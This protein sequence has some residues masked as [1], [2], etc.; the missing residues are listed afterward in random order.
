[1]PE[2]A[3]WLSSELGE[4][5]GAL[6]ALLTRV[7]SHPTSRDGLFDPDRHRRELVSG[8]SGDR[9]PLPASAVLDPV[10]RHFNLRLADLVGSGRSPRVTRPRQVAMYLCHRFTPA[11]TKEIGA[12]FA[13]GHSAVRNAIRVVERTI[14][15]RAT[16]RYQVEALIERLDP[17]RRSHF[18]P[19]DPG[20]DSR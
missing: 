8:P 12:I 15:E 20:G 13:R 18:G 5:L 16:R 11:S 4:N 9:P 6:D 14:L 1:M 10:C 7:L 17:D 19:G 3:S 2:A